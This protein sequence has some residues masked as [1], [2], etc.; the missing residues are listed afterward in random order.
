MSVIINA[1]INGILAIIRFSLANWYWAFA[2][3]AIIWLI[4]LEFS[5]IKLEFMDSEREVL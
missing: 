3:V 5:G 1:F 4:I 2:I